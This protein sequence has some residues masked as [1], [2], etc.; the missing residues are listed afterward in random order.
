VKKARGSHGD[1]LA[2]LEFGAGGLAVGLPVARGFDGGV[3][4]Q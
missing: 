2:D 1:D 3:V 4:R